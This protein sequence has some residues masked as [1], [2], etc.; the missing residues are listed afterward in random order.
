MGTYGGRL[1]LLS[2][3]RRF[4]GMI[5]SILSSHHGVE[6]I[7]HPTFGRCIWG[8]WPTT[9]TRTGWNIPGSRTGLRRNERVHVS[10]QPMTRQSIIRRGEQAVVQ[11]VGFKQLGGNGDSIAVQLKA[12]LVKGLGMAQPPLTSAH[13]PPASQLSRKVLATRS[14]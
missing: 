2:R 10:E 1:R 14:L 6:P 9:G 13:R 7:P 12:V 5:S 4:L 11:D 3:S 8:K